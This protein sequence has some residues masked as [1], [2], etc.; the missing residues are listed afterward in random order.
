MAKF[1]LILCYFLLCYAQIGVA[2]INI[3]ITK[4]ASE[5]NSNSLIMTCDAGDTDFRI[6]YVPAADHKSGSKRP[7]FEDAIREY[8][9]YNG[10]DRGSNYYDPKYIISKPLDYIEQVSHTYAYFDGAYG[11]MNEHQLAIAEDTCGAKESLKAKK[12]ARIFDIAE[13]SRLAMERCKTA[14][15]AV[16]L[17]GSMA[18]NYGYYGWGETLTVAD[19]KEI[20]V[21]EICASKDSKAM[22]VAKKIPNGE[23]FV[24][25]N[26][27]R[28][29]NIIPGT[30]GLLYSENLF[31]DAEKAGWYNPK[32]DKIFDWLKVVS[33]G[34]YNH[35]YYS[36]RRVWRIFDKAAPSK[37]FTSLVKNGYTKEYPFSVKPDNKLSMKDVL[38]LTRDWYQGTEFDLSKELA[39][40]PFGNINRYGGGKD[41]KGNWERAISMHRASYVYVTQS[42]ENLPDEIG[43]VVW[44]G[45]DAPHSTCFVPF[46][47]GV[48]DLPKAYQIGQQRHIDRNAAWW[49]F[50]YLSNILDLKFNYMIKDVEKEQNKIENR[51][52]NTQLKIEAKALELYKKNPKLAKEYLTKYCEANA[53]NVYKEWWKLSDKLI[54]KYQDGYEYKDD[55]FTSPGYNDKWLKGV[56]FKPINYAKSNS[57]EENKKIIDIGGDDIRNIIPK[58]K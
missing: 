27:F 28:I 32:E 36:L 44:W 21:F 11:I 43:G 22:W 46:Y 12:G 37:K 47:C 49:A 1:S 57:K 14:K 6:I 51:E 55:K 31:K 48:N 42:R 50:N 34:E 26:E 56:G 17:M 9:R 58:T 18:E 16:Q 41:I 2:C 45:C 13:L 23:I 40:G 35:P 20:W 30:K 24:S 29:R 5:T 10:K 3:A 52:I 39:A 7:V 38:N 33:P 54:L 53:N 19:T 15:E 4:G 8:P 25:A